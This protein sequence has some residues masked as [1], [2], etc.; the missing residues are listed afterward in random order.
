VGPTAAKA[1]SVASV[2]AVG[3]SGAVSPSTANK[4]A[5]M[6]RIA[7]TLNCV[8]D[9]D[10]LET[11]AMAVFIVWPI[12]GT[13]FRYFIGGVV[14]I[15]VFVL[16]LAAASVLLHWVAPGHVTVRRAQAKL[17][18]LIISYMLPTAVGY[19]TTIFVHAD[20][21]FDTAFAVIAGIAALAAYGGALYVVARHLPTGTDA[22]FDAPEKQAGGKR[23][24]AVYMLADGCLDARRQRLR[25]FFVE[26]VIA[27]SLM[28]IVA[29]A[30]PE[31]E[32]CTLM[33]V[34]V[35][36]IAVAHAA[37]V[38]FLRPYEAN[39]ENG[40]AIAI[41]F[42]Q[43]VL[44]SAVVWATSD[45]ESD[46]ARVTA[47]GVI[48]GL[49]GV[50]FLQ[51]VV[52]VGMWLYEQR[53]KLRALC[54]KDSV[55]EDAARNGL[56]VVPMLDD[57]TI[58]DIAPSPDV[59]VPVAAAVLD[60]FAAAAPDPFAAAV[61]DPFAAAVPDPFAAAVPDPFAAAAP[62]AVA[63]AF[64]ETDALAW[65]DGLHPDPTPGPVREAVTPARNEAP[66][67][68]PDPYLPRSYGA[69]DSFLLRTAANSAPPPLEKGGGLEDDDDN[70]DND[71]L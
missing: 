44:A 16:V 7:A 53:A 17:W 45:L 37:Y 62:A 26:D 27:S 33:A 4:A 55:D 23:L 36:V 50:L 20:A 49:F 57:A 71:G 51:T 14:V 25:V 8:F 40:F 24:Y 6:A 59:A 34:L 13:K 35:L 67:V 28:S 68:A 42:G 64:D 69:K 10:A 18:H 12:G 9:D 70:D 22:K 39:V 19:I 21:A 54:K 63:S 32:R 15:F 61:P 5:N 43:A 29:G 56:L 66:V 52:L 47:A 11:S 3:A 48:L 30:K 2:A 46:A 1:L 38:I 31:G 58:L 60:P 65:L 41:G